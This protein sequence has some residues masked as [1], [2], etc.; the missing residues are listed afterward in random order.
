MRRRWLLVL[1]AALLIYLGLGLAFGLRDL[2]STLVRVPLGWWLLATAVPLLGH[3]LL[4][5]R[6]QFYLHCL[7]YPLH[8]RASA[9]IYGA[10][11]AL[12]AAPGR[13]GE[14][15]RGLWL[16]RR[17]GFPLQV[18]VSVTLAER[19]ADMAG[20]LLVLSWGLG[21]RVWAAV[22]VGFAVLAAGG[23][24]LT[25]PGVLRRLERGLDHLPLHRWRGLMRLLREALLAMAGVRR[26]MRPG[27]LLLGTLLASVCW[28]LEA[29]VLQGLYAALG[30]SIGWHQAAV[31]RTATGLGGVLS[32]L[33]AGL[34]T[35]EATAIGLAVA[36]GAG[37]SDA[38]A[39]TL[40][41]RVATL[42]VPCLLGV[43]LLLRQRDLRSP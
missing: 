16:Q 15:L 23:W 11:L 21:Q 24:L 10:G 31:I 42:A 36:Y 33:P 27:P 34:G 6:W 32:L 3:L 25:H 12:I 22:L 4:C 29:G 17:H 5:R 9:R 13:S 38:L 8:W 30:S 40:M 26:L 41:L 2:A 19:L 7:G 28:L 39:V 35:S 18:G 14:A 37:R 43:V 1:V 20:A